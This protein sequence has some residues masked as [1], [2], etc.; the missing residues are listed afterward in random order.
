MKLFRELGLKEANDI[1]S[2][3]VV[4]IFYFNIKIKDH[5]KQRII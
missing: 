1:K 5:R 4:I 2:V 3:G